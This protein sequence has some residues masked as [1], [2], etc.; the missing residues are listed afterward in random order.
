MK[1]KHVG[2]GVVICEDV[3]DVDQDF[4]FEYI[5]WI[6]K[7]QEDTFTYTEEDGIE[8]AINK[9]GFKFKLE[10]VKQAPQR[11]LDTKGKQLNS[12]VPQKY[13]D[14]I[15]SLENAVYD[16]LVEYCCYFPDA[17]TT[18]WWR[19][20]GHIAGYEN[21]QRIGQHCDD[22]VPYEWGKPTGNQV[23]MHNSSS[24]NLYLNDCVDS[25]DQI[26][27]FN[28][29]GGEIHFPNVPYVWKPKAGSVAIYPSSY[30]GRHE[31]YPVDLGQRYAFLSIACYG[32]SFD[33]EEVVGQD[34]E[35]KHW[36]PNLIKDANNRAGKKNFLL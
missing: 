34:N 14:F 1:S 10:D 17:G 25:K 2:M 15:D 3:I 33:R 21:G 22:Q 35:Q 12:P 8:Y 5:N 4:L 16:A 29:T 19:P 26:N 30:I 27:S 36:M 24:I 31:V 32:T 18:S 13:I 9:T 6:R 28:Y 7:N 11:F 20:T 23:S